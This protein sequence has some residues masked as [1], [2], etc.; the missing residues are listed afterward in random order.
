VK[1]KIK[2]KKTII[3]IVLNLTIISK[4]SLI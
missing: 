2:S 3:F 4:K 1:Y